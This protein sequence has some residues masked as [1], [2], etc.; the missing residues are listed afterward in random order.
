VRPFRSD[1]SGQSIVLIAVSLPLILGLLLLVIDGGRLYVERE[2]IRNAAQ[3]AAEAAVS[4]AGDQPGRSA[5][6]ATQ[7]RDIVA[8]ALT[9]NLAGEAY[10]YDVANPFRTDLTQF[11]VKVSVTKP[12]R[13]SIGGVGFTIGAEAAALLSDPT[14]VPSGAPTPPPTPPGTPAPSPAGT[15]IPTASPTPSPV[16]S[17]RLCVDALYLGS[18]FT[19]TVRLYGVSSDVRPATTINS[20]GVPTFYYP[21]FPVGGGLERELWVAQTRTF[22]Y[23]RSATTAAITVSGYQGSVG[24]TIPFS[25]GLRTS[26]T[27]GT[28]RP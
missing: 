19:R 17:V 3:L 10:A 1:D 2:R 23:A 9:R 6:N 11:N 24:L 16:L 25:S 5:P 26:C 14:A 20:S 7:I 15:P 4:L 22:G 13:S 21:L 8:E 18:S 28:L 27:L 12:F